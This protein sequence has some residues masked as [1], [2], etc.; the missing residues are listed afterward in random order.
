MTGNQHA[1]TDL[2]A[3]VDE[4]KKPARDPL[5]GKALPQSWYA[6]AAVIVLA[7]DAEALRTRLVEISHDFRP[8][9]HYKELSSSARRDALSRIGQIADWDAIV[10]ES[11]RPV[12]IRKETTVRNGVLGRLLPSLAS[13]SDTRFATLESRARQ[14]TGLDTPD[15]EDRLLVAELIDHARLP[16]NFRI[17]H[18]HKDEPLLWAA[19]LIVGARTDALAGIDWRPWLHTAGRVAARSV[20]LRWLRP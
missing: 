13:E 5:T 18:A 6:M 20:P 2:I 16:A 7:G 1:S 12:P 17:T 8:R 15:H 10:V 4:S 3:F 19:D 9:L 14:L 11:E